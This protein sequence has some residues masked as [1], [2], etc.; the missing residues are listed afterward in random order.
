VNPAVGFAPLV[1]L[2]VPTPAVRLL[3]ISR[4]AMTLAGYDYRPPMGRV[5]AA[6]P[7]GHGGWRTGAA[8]ITGHVRQENQDA[9]LLQKA[10]PWQIALCADGLGGLPLGKDAS[11]LA[12]A[13]AA[14][15]L[16]RNLARAGEIEPERLR[17]LAL[18]GLLAAQKA[19]ALLAG[20]LGLEPDGGLRT[21]LTV[22]LAG[23]TCWAF[24]HAG[25]GFGIRIRP[26]QG[27]VE[28]W[29]EPQ[30]GAYANVVACSLG[31]RLEGMP[32]SGVRTWEPGEL[33][34]FGSDGIGDQV[35]LEGFGLHLREC[36][37][38]APGTLSGACGTLLD[39]LA[40]LRSE[41][42]YAFDDNL[43]LVVLQAPAGEDG[44]C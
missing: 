6:A 29:L 32:R 4:I 2:L 40:E 39:G 23:P 8:T 14:G 41:A 36:L 16:G 24:A 31:P 33:L 35:E 10:G 12:V 38:A 5:P 22:V 11:S 27:Q 44:P 3:R 1:P 43:S 21:T 42:G 26:G 9:V 25:D 18:S 34:A 20:F 17:G 7:A 15:W 19:L 28:A 37:L 13:V 30:K